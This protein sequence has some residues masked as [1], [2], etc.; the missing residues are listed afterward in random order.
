MTTS[1]TSIGKT[2]SLIFKTRKRKSG[3]FYTNM[4][5]LQFA[6]KDRVHAHGA[7]LLTQ[8]VPQT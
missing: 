6:T 4:Q 5:K 7:E 3:I 2:L 8:K 1:S